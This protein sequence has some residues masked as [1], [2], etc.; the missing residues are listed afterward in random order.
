MFFWV[1]CAALLASLLTFFSGFGLGT[2]LMPVMALF[3]SV[4]VAIALTGLVHLANN[5][6]KLILTGRY[7]HWYTALRFGL[8]AILASAAGAWL[9]TGLKTLP[10]IA[11]W[12]WMDNVFQITLINLVIAILLMVFVVLELSKGKQKHFLDR[13]NLLLGGLMSGFFGGLSGYQGALRSVFLVRAG[14][15]KEAFIATGVII[16]CCIDVSRL[17]IYAGRFQIVN[18]TGNA[19]LLVCAVFA[20]FAGAFTGSRLLKK[21]TMKWVQTWVSIALMLMAIAIGSGVI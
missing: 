16:A 5:I 17:L 6:F 21:V 10:V 11:T 8:P 2:L 12:Y 13:G 20:A 7:I 4:E 14:L 1:C 3:F 15:D 19:M 18:W 9:L